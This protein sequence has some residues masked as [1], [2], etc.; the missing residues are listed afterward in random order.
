MSKLAILGGP[1]AIPKPF[2]K[3][4]S[5]G[6][7][8]LEAVKA[9][10]ETGVLSRFLGCWD[11]DFYGGEKIQEFEREWA[12]YFSVNH[13]VTVNSNTSGLIAAL[14]AVGIE[15]GDEVIVSPWTMSASATS[16]LVWNGIPVFADIE[17]ETFNLDPAAVEKNITPYTRAIMVPDIFG[18]AADL[19]RIMALAR[20]H[21]LKVIEDAAQAPGALYQGRQVGTIADIGVYSLNYH[22]HIHTGEGGVC[23]TNDPALA[24][25]M[26]LIRNHGEAVVGDKGVEDLSNMIG[27]NFRMTEMEAAVGLEQLKK[28]PKLV[29][30]R[31]GAADRLTAGIRHLQGLR[32]PVVRPGCTHVYY[33]YP[34]VYRASETGIP[35]P[36]VLK[37][38][39]AEGL[40]IASGY[41]NLHLLP[42]YQ[43]RIAYGKRG[44]PWTADIYQGRVSYEKGIC[45]VAETLQDESFL[46]IGL[47]EY[48]FTDQEIDQMIGAFRKVWD[49]LGDLRGH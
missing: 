23:V 43:Q 11:P 17:A 33:V 13:A 6:R 5:I 38:L 2:S 1:K 20:R 27:F 35:R 48:T 37:A 49:H 18:H 28:L 44:F 15:P 34:L 21:H 9:V 4:N 7:E 12:R 24:E 41:E 46:L 30:Q 29:A 36:T 42:L 40:P 39:E 45:P 19:E 26:Q 10:I 14:G 8:E 25:R 31:A 16:I 47:C 22:K 3:Y 32:V